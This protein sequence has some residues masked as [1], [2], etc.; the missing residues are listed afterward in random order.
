MYPVSGAFLTTYDSA[1]DVLSKPSVTFDDLINSGAVQGFPECEPYILS[2]I[3][4]DGKVE[5]RV[6]A[7]IADQKP[8]QHTH[9][10]SLASLRMWRHSMQMSPSS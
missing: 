9:H 1:F 5:R 10:T 6:S 8:Q 3:I 7:L 4:T 2:R